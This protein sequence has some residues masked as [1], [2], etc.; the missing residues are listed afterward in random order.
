MNMARDMTRSE[1]RQSQV[2]QL[3]KL[4][5]SFEDNVALEVLRELQIQ[6][7]FECKSLGSLVYKL[8]LKCHKQLTNQTIEH[9]LQFG[10]AKSQPSVSNDA[11]LPQLRKDNQSTPTNKTVFP[12]LSVPNDIFI[13]LGKYFAPSDAINLGRTG[14]EFYRLTQ[15]KAFLLHV[16]SGGES[17]VLT[18]SVLER[19]LGTRADPWTHAVGCK[20]LELSIGKGLKSTQMIDSL[21]KMIAS[22]MCSDW[23]AELFRNV[24]TIN[25]RNDLAF[26]PINVLFSL[27]PNKDRAPLTLRFDPRRLHSASWSDFLNNYERYYVE[28][29]G[30]VRS[31]SCLSWMNSHSLEG[32]MINASLLSRLHANYNFLE[33]KY[34]A[35]RV[36][37]F[38]FIKST[39]HSK[40]NTLH[41]RGFVFEWENLLY[42]ML[43]AAHEEGEML[44]IEDMGMT[45]EERI[46][47]NG[48]CEN[49]DHSADL[50]HVLAGNNGLPSWQCLH[51]I[52]RES[53][54]FEASQ[55]QMI[56]A[57]T[58]FHRET[59]FNFAAHLYIKCLRKWLSNLLKSGKLKLY[60]T[61]KIC[62]IETWRYS[63][64]LSCSYDDL[65]RLTEFLNDDLGL[66]LLNFDRTVKELFI[67]LEA[68]VCKRNSNTSAD[69]NDDE[70]FANWKH[71]FVQMASALSRKFVS[72]ESFH[73][74]ATLQLDEDTN[75]ADLKHTIEE[76]S[77][78]NL[79]LVKR[80]ANNFRTHR[81]NEKICG[82][83]VLIIKPI[84][85]ETLKRLQFLDEKTWVKAERNVSIDTTNQQF[86]KIKA[87]SE[88]Q[89]Q[90]LLESV[91]RGLVVPL[92]L[93]TRFNSH[94]LN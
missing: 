93:V 49:E 75:S 48:V 24:G 29:N 64:N 56:A 51:T 60:D 43:Q 88:A 41:S 87:G 16:N 45:E 78:M 21:Q 66:Q 69:G 74:S 81:E 67:P 47:F 62:K 39:F 89:K 25:F 59:E 36:S 77:A 27:D 8:V 50:R 18:T 85:C 65:I 37:R 44:K 57:L 28:Q 26:V 94:L 63:A 52:A 34:D 70:I 71:L 54:K 83:L 82:A 33:I 73:I 68:T 19:V 86:K 5:P 9:L 2:F 55:R 7:E 14:H 10:R 11:P 38:S 13:E 3:G 6:K 42:N 80:M 17:F 40:M 23:F 58:T 20:Y 79:D 90:W 31:I 53:R 91:D 1:S 72:L 30:M 35:L 92:G 4:L 15:R 22:D 61:S 12:L 46:K 32:S 84:D 76:Y